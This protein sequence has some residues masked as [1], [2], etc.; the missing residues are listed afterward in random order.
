MSFIVKPTQGD[1]ERCPAGMHLARCYSIIDLGTQR[2]E[3][4]GQVKHQHKI[5]LGWEIHGTTDDGT[6][7]QMKDGRPFA[8][9][10]EYTHSWS[11]TASLRIDL[12]AWRGREFTPEEMQAF[13]LMNIMGAWCMLNIIDRVSEKGKTYSN[14]NG[15]TPVPAIMKKSGLPNAVNKNEVFNLSEP[16]MAMFEGFSTF[17]KTKIESS[18]EWQRLKLSSSTSK[19]ATTSAP[20]QSDYDDSDIPF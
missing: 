13:D 4:K 18:P 7:L 10:K 5:R 15:I 6:P 20:E 19:A 9:F 12:Q 11:D 14:I 17:M 8:I 1:F 16:D 3:Y 2:S